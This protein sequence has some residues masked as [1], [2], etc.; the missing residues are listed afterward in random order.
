MS[1]WRGPVG[2]VVV[3]LDVPELCEE[4]PPAEWRTEGVRTGAD[5]LAVLAEDA[6]DSRSGPLY[7]TYTVVTGRGGRHPYFIAP[8][9]A[10]LGNTAGE[11]G[12]LVDTRAHGGYV[13]AAESI[14]AG[15]P[16]RRRARP[17]GPRRGDRGHAQGA[18]G[19][20][21]TLDAPFRPDLPARDR[22]A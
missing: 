7:D 5:V 17:A 18:D 10:R 2:L 1:V 8:D 11:L 13:L 3:D 12:W 14:V 20:V 19:P 4:T 22:G 16:L 6:P 9:G 15:R 21:R